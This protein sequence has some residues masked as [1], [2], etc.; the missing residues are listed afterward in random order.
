MAP[1]GDLK[2]EGESND[3][4]GV[5]INRTGLVTITG[6]AEVT[7]DFCVP[8]SASAPKGP[9]R[10]RAEIGEAPNLGRSAC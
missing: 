8:R 5:T 10:T 4:Q 2:C 9:T 1:Q 7:I 3:G 6:P